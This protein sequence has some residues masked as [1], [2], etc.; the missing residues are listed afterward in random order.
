M[1]HELRLRLAGS[2]AARAAKIVL[3][4]LAER[5]FDLPGHILVDIAAADVANDGGDVLLTIEALTVVAD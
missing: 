1:R 5:E 4:D 2:A 3:V